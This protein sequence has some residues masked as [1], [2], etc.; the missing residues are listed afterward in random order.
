MKRLIILEQVYS[1]LA[2]SSRFYER[3]EPGCGRYFHVTLTGEVETLVEFHGIHPKRFGLRCLLSRTFPCGVFY[4]E[5]KS[6]IEVVAVFDLRR[7]PSRLRQ[8]LRKR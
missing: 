5:K 1:D 2:E 4:R 3:Q 8:Q 6:A 7:N